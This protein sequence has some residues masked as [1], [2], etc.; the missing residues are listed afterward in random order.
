MTAGDPPPCPFCGDPYWHL[1]DIRHDCYHEHEQF[2]RVKSLMDDFANYCKKMEKKMSSD[3]E[4]KSKKIDDV[5]KELDAMRAIAQAMDGL[6]DEECKK[7]L[8]WAWKTYVLDPLV[9]NVRQSNSDKD[10]EPNVVVKPVDP[11]N[12]WKSP[13]RPV[14]GIE[15]PPQVVLYGV[16]MDPYYPH[17]DDVF[18]PRPV[19]Y[20]PTVTAYAAPGLGD[21]RQ[22]CQS[23]TDATNVTVTDTVPTTGR[24]EIDTSHP[25]VRHRRPRHYKK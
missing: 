14:P 1:S 4:K 7:V 9:E 20:P 19:V 16:Y 22:T 11:T 10:T 6:S 5:C 17:P 25:V 18:G 2:T 15:W 23:I 21:D 8:N 12:P 24:I 3:S 13:F